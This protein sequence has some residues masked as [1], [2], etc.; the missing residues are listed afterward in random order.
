MGLDGF[1]NNEPYVEVEK[2]I[3]LGDTVT[4]ACKKSGIT[5]QDY[6]H[7]RADN[8]EAQDGYKRAL[9]LQI[10]F[11]ETELKNR[12]MN[13]YDEVTY[14]A[15]GTAV[16]TIH[17]HDND[18]LLRLLAARDARYKNGHTGDTNITLDFG[19]LLD[20]AQNRY[21]KLANKVIDV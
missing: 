6:D 11:Y 21:K 13:G 12:A 19:M 14:D 18:L 10:E 9:E 15:N 7:I 3:A 5:V 20:K 2:R 17:K 8:I 4:E 16:K 1:L